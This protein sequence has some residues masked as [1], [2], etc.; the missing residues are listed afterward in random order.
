MARTAR[1]RTE[2]RSF[3]SGDY[4][5]RLPEW[6]E[7]IARDI[8]REEGIALTPE[9]CEVIHCLREL[10]DREGNLCSGPAILRMLEDRFD[11]EGGGK[12]LYR[13]FPKGPVHQGMHIAGLP[14]P[15]Y[16]FDRSFGSVT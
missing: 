8:A 1:L 4:L 7:D 9:H 14:A 11:R 10:Y 13:L 3:I 12:Y 15:I 16:S 6:S 5:C 2:M